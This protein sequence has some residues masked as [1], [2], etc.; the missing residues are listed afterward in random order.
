MVTAPRK[1]T[2][3]PT[4]EWMPG[5]VVVPSYTVKPAS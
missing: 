5:S 3:P 4:S 1:I 2:E